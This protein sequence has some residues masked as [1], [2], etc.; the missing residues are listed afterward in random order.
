MV[1]LFVDQAMMVGCIPVILADEIEFPFENSLHWP[2][3]TVKIAEADCERVLEILHAIPP[4]QIAAKQARFLRRHSAQPV[5][6]PHI[7]L[8]TLVFLLSGMRLT[9]RTPTS[10]IGQQKLRSR[11]TGRGIPLSA[12][13]PTSVISG[14]LRDWLV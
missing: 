2:S 14:F 3:L 8:S 9:E 12:R 11:D 10:G 6:F 4:E 5:R 13:M 1:R 7:S